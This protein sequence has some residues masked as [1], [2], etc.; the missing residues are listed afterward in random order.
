MDANL[1]ARQDPESFHNKAH[2]PMINILVPSPD[3]TKTPH[4]T[5]QAGKPPHYKTVSD[6][7]SDVS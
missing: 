7:H 3:T 1:N 2:C 5:K 4:H 6:Q